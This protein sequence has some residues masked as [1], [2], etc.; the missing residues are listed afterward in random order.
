M[1]DPV[2]KSDA[3][4]SSPSKM[5]GLPAFVGLWTLMFFNYVQHVHTDPWSEHDHSRNFVGSWLNF[6]LFNN[7][8]H[9]AHHENPGCHWSKLPEAHAR[10]AGAME[11]SL[12]VPNTAW[13]LVKQYLLSPLFPSL[14]TKQIGRPPFD[15]A[16][17]LVTGDVD[18]VEA[19]VNAS[20]V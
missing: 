8:L 10:I 17:E 3:L 4:R 7:G 1:L 5:I 19:G 12:N 16:R 2:P 9:A 18:A 14:G 6:L 15:G 20:M 13:W 11:P